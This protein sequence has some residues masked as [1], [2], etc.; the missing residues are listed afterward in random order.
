MSDQSYSG[1]GYRVREA[2]PRASALA[3]NKKGEI[4]PP[5]AILVP[6]DGSVVAEY[7]LHAASKVAVETGAALSLLYAIP[8]TAT[9]GADERD[10]QRKAMREARNYLDYTQSTLEQRRIATTARVLPGDPA[11][12]ILFAAE[13]PGIS[14][15]SMATRGRGGMRRT[16]RGSVAE[17]VLQGSV[18]PLLLSQA[19]RWSNPLTPRPFARIL[20]A[21]DGTSFA[22]AAVTFV[23]TSGIGRVGEIILVQVVQP[24]VLAE[25]PLSTPRPE[26]DQAQQL[27]D[28]HTEWYQHAAE[29]YLRDIAAGRLADRHFETSVQVGE[30]AHGILEVAQEKAVDLIVVATH[31]RH[32]IDRALHGSVVHHL[33]NQIDAPVILLHGLSEGK[34]TDHRGAV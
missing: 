31:A 30:P 13:E 19:G 2:C 27:A 11:A 33:L 29:K 22:E 10:A 1:V 25:T 14:L 28:R 9:A 20:L 34:E 6:L 7:G 21:L 16:I 15:I 5:E 26:L 32:G 23:A 8:F 18:C 12:A 24:E 4:M 3:M 17:S